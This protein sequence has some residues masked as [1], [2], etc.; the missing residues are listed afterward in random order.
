MAYLF[1]N[2]VNDPFNLPFSL[3]L[4]LI[5]ANTT[6]DEISFKNDFLAV[7]LGRFAD[8]KTTSQI[9]KEQKTLTQDELK[10]F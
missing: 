9:L 7:R 4:E 10:S 5:K 8:K 6:L 1:K 3:F 2:G